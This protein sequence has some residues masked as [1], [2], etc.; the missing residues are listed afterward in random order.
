ML[1]VAAEIGIPDLLGDGPQEVATLAALTGAEPDVLGRVLRTLASA[2]VFTE[3][4][5][6]MFGLTDLAEPLRRDAPRSIR[7]LVLEL[8]SAETFA[9]LGAFEH[10]LRTGEPSFDASFGTDHWSYLRTRPARAEVFNRT[11]ALTA[12]EV[13]SRALAGYDLSDAKLVVDVAGG[14]GDLI[15]HLLARYPSL[16]GVLFDQPEVVAAAQAT[17]DRLDVRDRVRVVGGDF[18]ESVPAG[19]DVY[20]LTMILH[21]WPDADAV[22]IL[23]SVR[24]AMSPGARVLVVDAIIPPGDAPHPGKYVDILMLMLYG[25]RERTEAEFAALFAA[26][27]LRL[28]EVISRHTPS[29]LLVLEA[30]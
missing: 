4:A 10:S 16:Q 6:G 20:L 7:D 23:R 24:A 12:R 22:R 8:G 29:S 26:A 15:G 17:F 25:G 30:V 11:Q 14:Y 13:H 28:V 21:D 9:T 3:T 1:A 2:G 27:D 19:G 5:P 18:F